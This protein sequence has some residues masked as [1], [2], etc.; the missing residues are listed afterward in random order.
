MIRLQSW[1]ASGLL[2]WFLAT[3]AMSLSQP[4]F[5]AHPAARIGAP[6]QNLPSTGNLHALVLFG[7]FADDNVSSLTTPAFADSLF[8]ADLPG[9]LTH[10]FNEMSH[11]Q[12]QLSG[13]VP[14]K[15]YRSRDRAQDYVSST[16]GV[17]GDFGRFVEEIVDAADADIDFGAYDNDGPDGEPNSGDDDG[18][19]DALFVVV[20]E[21]PSRFLVSE[22]NGVAV[23]GLSS[24][25][26]TD[27]LSQNGG[28]ILIRDDLRVGKPPGGTIQEGR[29][30][31]SA[32]GI[33]AHELGHLLGLPDLFDTGF[34]S[35]G[36]LGPADDSAGIG[37][38]GLMGHGARGWQDL[39]GPTSF[40]P[41]SLLRLGWLGVE[42]EDLVFVD[43]TRTDELID[44]PADG[45]RVYRMALEP[46]RYLLIEHRRAGAS[47]YNRRIP[48]DG[49]LIWQIDENTGGNN[50]ELTKLVDLVCA[51]GR[52]SDA[53]FPLGSQPARTLGGDNLDFWAHDETYRRA[54][55]GNLGDATD[56]FDGEMFTD[57]N[58]L[59]NPA[60][61][62]VAVEKIRREGTS[63]IA[64][65]IIGDHRKAGI[66]AGDETWSGPVD[67]VA[68]IEIP[69][70]VRLRI[71]AG[72]TVRFFPDG[73]SG[74]LDVE[75]SEI[76]VKG[77]LS[78]GGGAT[79][80]F[81]SGA[82]SPAAGDWAG[83]RVQPFGSLLLQNA[84]VEYADN[85][86][87]IVDARRSTLVED[88]V[89][90][91][92]AGNA[93]HL[94]AD[95][96]GYVMTRITLEDV[97][98]T[99]LLLT[100]E[101][102]VQIEEPQISLCG[103]PG[104]HREGGFL[105]CTGGDFLDN[106]QAQAGLINMQLGSGVFGTI[107]DNRFRGGTGV[108]VDG[109]GQV[110]IEDNLFIETRVAL[111]H[112]N[113]HAWINGNT[114]SRSDTAFQ[115]QGVTQP[116]RME[117]NRLDNVSL[118]ID[119]RT[120][121]DVVAIRNWW[122]TADH[123]SIASR[124]LGAVRFEPFLNFD[125]LSPVTFDIGPA[126]PNPS[127]GPVT[128]PF[129]VGIGEIT[130]AG[131][132]S[133]MTL[134]IHNVVGGFVRQLFRGLSVPGIYSVQWDGLNDQGHAA[135]AGLYYAELDVGGLLL[136]SPLLRLR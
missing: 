97:G 71:A 43:R 84:V 2:L 34:S 60:S 70:G 64:D 11:G 74:G 58:P 32:V 36:E 136:Y 109:A 126:F 132:S 28:R 72:T 86:L 88:V 16:A 13:A 101:A 85:A 37:Y 29:T 44:D 7:T 52:F 56:V 67:V 33:I 131:Q 113:G 89:I 69:E 57:F 45:G 54:H 94:D 98:A 81:T 82:S 83:I 12:Y 128:I 114:I 135:A 9:S 75:R 31:A 124:M 106:G 115:I 63:I 108:F 112:H 127:T 35:L 20:P 51:D 18:F 61:R 68:D 15:M 117:L 91:H 100:G 105:E 6:A 77:V 93:V 1:L 23:L 78:V 21:T 110:K 129:T 111:V 90:R 38:W 134:D 24:N 120:S 39:G 123:A 121:A 92:V 46:A 5:C 50:N 49:L 53:G 95:E 42:N 66:L 55:N 76:L 65:L 125:P 99:G 26:F 17:S 80:T 3:P 41:W 119:N 14:G 48:T 87:R 22:A 25:L 59:T 8:L 122:G 73:R 47:F 116:E 102:P 62:G 79:T 130:L 103:G 107:A 104:L 118:L 10:F 27:D 40:T 19:V 30:F 96:G 133:V 4:S